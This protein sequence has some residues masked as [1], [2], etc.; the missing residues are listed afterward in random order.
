MSGKCGFLGV[1]C[2]AAAVTLGCSAGNGSPS[3]VVGTEGTGGTNGAPLGAG[4]SLLVTSDAGSVKTLSAHI[5]Q[6]DIAVT[7]V[8]LQC[9]NSCANVVAVATGG[10]E[11]YAFVWEDGSTNPSRTLCPTTADRFR[12]AVTDA[13]RKTVEFQEPPKTVTATITAQVLDCPHDAGLGG[14][15]GAIGA[16]GSAGSGGLPTTLCQSGVTPPFQLMRAVAAT[17]TQTLTQANGTVPGY[18]VSNFG[19]PAPA[20]IVASAELAVD[21]GTC[22]HLLLAAD[23]AGTQPVGWDNDVILEYRVA[24]GAPVQKRWYYG[25]PVTILDASSLAL[26]EPLAPTVPGTSLVPPVPNPV[27]FGYAPLALDLMSELPSG[28][29][30]FDLTLYVIDFGGFGSVTDLWA[31]PR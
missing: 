8:T 23:A 5:E 17:A 30:S 26:V 25:G 28:I 29:S 1:V 10:Y 11:P 2:L 7:F 14:A 13:G 22:T 31:I 24:A 20:T 27:P 3:I 4:G 12:V 21:I 6:H 18:S 19:L 15:G 16:G 9:S